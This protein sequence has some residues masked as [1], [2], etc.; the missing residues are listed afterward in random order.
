VSGRCLTGDVFVVDD[1]PVNIRR[2]T[3]ILKSVGVAPRA[4]TS[5]ARALP[6]IREKCPDLLLLDVE[7]PGQDGWA[8]LDALRADERTR[9][10]RVVFVSAHDSPIERARAFRSGAS[11]WLTKPFDDAEVL[12]RVA[13]QLEIVALSRENEVLRAELERRR[14]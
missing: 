12:A 14:P 4:A 11:D 2:I 1:N 5:G 10:I 7:M 6:A 8:V 13:A 9:G 3:E